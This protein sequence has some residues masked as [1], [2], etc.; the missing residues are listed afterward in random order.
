MSGLVVCLTVAIIDSLTRS[1]EWSVVSEEEEQRLGL[2]FDADG[3]FWMSFA[4][5]KKNF[6]NIEITNLTPDSLDE[7]RGNLS[8]ILV[9]SSLPSLCRS[10]TSLGSKLLRRTMDSWST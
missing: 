6:T 2:S 1:R 7:G 8:F 5:F 4:D 9:S 3:E 10:K